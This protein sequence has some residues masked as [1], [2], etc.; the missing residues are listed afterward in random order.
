MWH[1]PGIASI[2]WSYLFKSWAFEIKGFFPL[3]SCIV[4]LVLDK[5]CFD[6]AVYPV[7]RVFQWLWRFFSLSQFNFLGLVIH[8]IHVQLQK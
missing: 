4:F 8:Y 1:M 7:S 2:E 3:L 6:S 5:K